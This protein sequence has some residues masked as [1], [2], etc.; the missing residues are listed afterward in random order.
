MAIERSANCLKKL[1]RLNKALR[2]EEGD[3]IPLSD[4]YWSTF[5][6]RW[7][8]ELGL[9]A[10]AD[11]YR[12]YDLD[13]ICIT[14]N[15]DPHIKSFQVIKAT[16]ED[17]ILKTGFEATIRKKL[18][19]QMPYFES[20]DT[21]DLEKM[22]AF[23]FDDPRDDRRFFKGGDD[24]LNGI[25]D[26]ISRNIPAWVG[27]VKDYYGDF[28]VYGSIC[29][30]HEYLWRIIGSENVLLWLA[31]YPDEI[32]AFVRRI[33]DFLVESTKAQIEAADGMLAGIVIWGDVAYRNGMLFSPA[34][35]REHFKPIVAEQIKICHGAGI[36][37]IYH[38]CGNA[39]EIFGDFIEMGL[40]SYNPLEAK[41]GLDVVELRRQYGHAM[42]FCG[43]IDALAWANDSL[44][45]LEAQVMRKLNAAKGGGY[46]IQSD[47][48]VPSN[49]SAERY[50]FVLKL[51]RKHG[52]YPLEL[53]AW[54]DPSIS[55]SR[56]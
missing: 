11:I 34:M 25:G 40:D 54:D 6:S 1:E 7:R 5:I 51:L 50:E 30:G 9:A 8:K 3:R 32:E 22:A 47:H 10:D 41:S 53:G 49:V 55:G 20:F 26:V 21:D 16:D 39:S 46:L 14:P 12:Y 37:V 56:R 33:G 35:W 43:N 36:P 27:R 2:H 24:Q 18:G 23:R 38:G 4:F 44:P 31:L 17:V 28:P 19:T 45:E 52:N 13:W 42:G 15:M 29:E 48:S